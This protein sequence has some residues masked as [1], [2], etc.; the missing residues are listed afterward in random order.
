MSYT[1]SSKSVFFLIPTMTNNNTSMSL[2]RTAHIWP[3]KAGASRSQKKEGK[4]INRRRRKNK[5]TKLLFRWKSPVEILSISM[6]NQPNVGRCTD[7]LH[8]LLSRCHRPMLLPHPVAGAA[9]RRPEWVEAWPRRVPS[10]RRSNPPHWEPAARPPCCGPPAGWCCVDAAQATSSDG[11]PK[12]LSTNISDRKTHAR[13]FRYFLNIFPF[14]EQHTRKA[15]QSCVC[16]KETLDANWKTPKKSGKRKNKQ[17]TKTESET[18]NAPERGERRKEMA[19]SALV[20][21]RTHRV[22]GI[23]PFYKRVCSMCVCACLFLCVYVR[24]LNAACLMSILLLLL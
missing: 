23:C 4:N 17:W 16:L 13:I 7:L 10:P 22:A 5:K 14:A 1:W 9:G 15:N 20:H 2:N 18:F 8:S 3:N 24:L 19:D 21:S 12:P 6:H 11:P